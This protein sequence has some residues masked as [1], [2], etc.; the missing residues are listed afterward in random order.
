MIHFYINTNTNQFQVILQKEK[1]ISTCCL[2]SSNSNNFYFC[3]NKQYDKI[4][5]HHQFQLQEKSEAVFSNIETNRQK[6]A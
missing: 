1:Q 3:I 5:M 4:A 2:Y 6:S